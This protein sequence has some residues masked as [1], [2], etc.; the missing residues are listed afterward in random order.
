MKQD[1]SLGDMLKARL[2]EQP[3]KVAKLEAV[4][5][6]IRES[7][8]YE[9]KAIGASAMHWSRAAAYEDLS[10]FTV[11][12]SVHDECRLQ[13]KLLE[14]YDADIRKAIQAMG[15]INKLVAKYLD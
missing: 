14:E 15:V 12:E 1:L 3:T 4:I 6:K 2:A 11:G 10:E 8:E 5:Q 13:F 9:I 7:R